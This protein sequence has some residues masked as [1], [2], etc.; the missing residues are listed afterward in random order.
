M[1]QILRTRPEAG[2][3]GPEARPPRMA[4]PS[5]FDALEPKEET[6]GRHLKSTDGRLRRQEEVTRGGFQD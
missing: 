6:E 1:S 2:S 4:V 5:S 3:Q